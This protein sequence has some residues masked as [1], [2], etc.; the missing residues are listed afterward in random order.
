M[1]VVGAWAEACELS[2]GK[3]M[4]SA[5]LAAFKSP[6]LKQIADK[7]ERRERSDAAMAQDIPFLHTPVSLIETHDQRGRVL[8]LPSLPAACKRIFSREGTICR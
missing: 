7:A 4:S 3:I 5:A 6:D 8:P 2:N 1:V